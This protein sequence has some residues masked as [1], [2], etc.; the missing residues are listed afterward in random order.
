MTRAERAGLFAAVVLSVTP[1]LQAQAPSANAQR[2]IAGLLAEKAARN[3]AQRKMSSHLVHAAKI[4][5]GE[6]VHPDYPVPPDARAAVRVD[7][8]N[9][10]EVD[11][12]ANV[13]PELLAAIA[14][15]GGTVVNSYPQYRSLRANLPLLAVEQIAARGEV[16][17]IRGAAQLHHGSTPARVLPNRASARRSIA[18]QLSRFFRREP[19][20]APPSF[21]GI[22]RRLG[23]VFFVG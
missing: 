4:L 11:I 15:L 3:P 2:Q 21:G 10:V 12:R 14:N 16:E 1:T 22:F 7:A 5:R 13:T 19:S 20:A 6:P 8:Q 23:S 18:S 17:Q 9:Q